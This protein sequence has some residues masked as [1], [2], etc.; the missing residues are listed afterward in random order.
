MYEKLIPRFSIQFIIAFNDNEL[1]IIVV[2][3]PPGPP[4][5]CKDEGKHCPY[6]KDQGYC[7]GTHSTYMKKYCKKSCDVC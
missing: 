5:E 4:S 7:T 6:W 1:C 2:I 3:P